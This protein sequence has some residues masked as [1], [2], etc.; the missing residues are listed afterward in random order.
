VSSE[1]PDVTVTG[2][3]VSEIDLIIQTATAGADEG[4]EPFPG[5]KHDDQVDSTTQALQYMASN[6][7]SEIWAKLGRS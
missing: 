7:S 3:E 5:S 6:T 2:F 1:V 4:D